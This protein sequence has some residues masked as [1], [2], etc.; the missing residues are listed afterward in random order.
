V[1]DKNDG[2]IWYA[3]FRG[4]RLYSIVV[5]TVSNWPLASMLMLSK[6][7][8]MIEISNRAGGNASRI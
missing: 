1:G 8:S 4:D 3:L 5:D 7:F 6:G 2:Q